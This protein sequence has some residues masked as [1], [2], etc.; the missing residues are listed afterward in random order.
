M[1]K[2]MNRVCSTGMMNMGSKR[3][4]H[5]VGLGWVFR[6]G[7]GFGKEGWFRRQKRRTR[8]SK[9]KTRRRRDRIN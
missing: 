9:R 8:R 6:R 4:I 3:L 2:R 1:A 7:V 5:D